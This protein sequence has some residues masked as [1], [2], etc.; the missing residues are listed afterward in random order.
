MFTC[1]VTHKFRINDNYFNQHPIA[2]YSELDVLGQTIKVMVQRA[3][4]LGNKIAVKNY[5]G[6]ILDILWDGTCLSVTENVHKP[7]TAAWEKFMRMFPH[8][9]HFW[10]AK[11]VQNNIWETNDTAGYYFKAMYMAHGTDLL[12]VT[13]RE[14]DSTSELL[15]FFSLFFRVQINSYLELTLMLHNYAQ[16]HGESAIVVKK[17]VIVYDSAQNTGTKGVRREVS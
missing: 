1:K 17:S 6:C 3:N 7:E 9:E 11:D 5:S 14:F 16:K 12:P 10:R 2:A 4:V 8:I 15:D 13:E